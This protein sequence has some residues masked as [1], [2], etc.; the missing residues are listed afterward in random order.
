MQCEASAITGTSIA[1]RHNKQT[2]ALG[3]ALCLYM[4]NIHSNVSLFVANKQRNDRKLQELIEL[5]GGQNYEFLMISEELK[6]F[7]D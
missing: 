4:I 6:A 5:P 3:Q 2:A 1:A 7:K